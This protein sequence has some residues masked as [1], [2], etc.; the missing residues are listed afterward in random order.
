MQTKVLKSLLKLFEEHLLSGANEIA[1]Q[2]EKE[3]FLDFGGQWIQKSDERLTLTALHSFCVELANSR[4]TRFDVK[5]PT[6]ST[7]IPGT[8]YRVQAMHQSVLSGQRIQI[9]IRIPGPVFPIASFELDENLGYTYD[10]LIGW[11]KNRKNILISGG[12]GSGKTSLLNTL[13]QE[14]DPKERV[15]TIEDSPEIN[16]INPNKTQI[17]VSKKDDDYFTYIDGINTSMRLSPTRLILG[18]LDTRNTLP[19]LRL[20]NTGHSGSV[21]TIHANTSEDALNAIAVN[22]MFHHAI[23][24]DVLHDYIRTGL[25]Y[26]IQIVFNRAKNKRIITE[27]TDLKKMLLRKS[28]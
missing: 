24:K 4:E 18:E 11:V 26:I 17:L 22:A 1:I 25:D 19:F 23:T 28:A 5:N 21:S 14:I 13:L 16:L 6:L 27:V 9:N 10:D 8:K 7:S 15:V 20:N 3:L 12:T 2:T